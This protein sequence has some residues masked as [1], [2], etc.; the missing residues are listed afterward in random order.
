MRKKR[1][2]KRAAP[3]GRATRKSLF[4]RKLAF[5]LDAIPSPDGDPYS[6][7]EIAKG[8][9]LSVS[10]LAMLKHGRRRNPTLETVKALTDFF[11]VP[12]SFF[13]EDVD[14]TTLQGVFEVREIQRRV[15]EAQIALTDHRL[16]EAETL[17]RGVASG[18]HPLVPQVLQ[19]RFKW[20]LGRLHRLR[21]NHIR[22]GEILRDAL[23]THPATTSSSQRVEIL[24]ELGRVEY[25]QQRYQEA[26][27][28]Y[29]RALEEITEGGQGISENQAQTLQLQA[30]Q[31]LGVVS[32][33]LGRLEDSLRY[34]TEGLA[35]AERMA[36]PRRLAHIYMGLGLVHKDLDRTE[37]A[38][39]ASTQALEIY[40]SIE[41]VK[42]IADTQHNMA[43]ALLASERYI[44]ARQLLEQS[45]RTHQT[46]RDDRGLGHDHMA[47]GRYFF[48]TG[49]YAQ[50]R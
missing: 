50:A 1:T 38:L 49:D 27:R 29:N 46:V 12:P 39:Q 42:L 30:L 20:A 35:L 23:T 19:S 11:G 37:A 15:N 13:Y 16:E 36:D 32:R 4:A 28:H 6:L 45:L 17:L 34:L 31:A 44:E 22:A 10:Y 8:T 43:L 26:F 14:P 24:L 9:R 5:L 2:V 33:R 3:V 41:D 48:N 40:R 25:E 21:G 47:L 7:Q 18:I